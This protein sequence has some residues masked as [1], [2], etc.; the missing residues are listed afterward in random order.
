[1][2]S[3]STNIHR[4]QRALNMKGMKI[5]YSTSQF[6]SE[7]QNRPVTLYVIKKAVYDE[8]KDRNVNIELFKSTSQI[9]ILL[10]LRDLWY[11]VNDKELP[12]SNETWN[13]IRDSIKQDTLQV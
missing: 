1:M 4:L 11:E 3:N 8:E 13:K 12:Q 5:L 7:D 9:Q 6:Y 2:A 10:Y